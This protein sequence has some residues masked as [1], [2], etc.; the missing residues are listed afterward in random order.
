M[1]AEAQKFLS[2]SGETLSEALNA[3]T[4]DINTLVNKTIEDTM[5]NAKQYEAARWVENGTSCF[6]SAGWS[7]RLT[8][9]LHVISRYLQ[10]VNR[11]NKIR[12]HFCYKKVGGLSKGR[13]RK[14]FWEMLGNH[15]LKKTREV[16][17]VVNKG[18]LSNST[19]HP[20]LHESSMREG[21]LGNVESSNGSRNHL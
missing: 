5:I 3:F 4:S 9:H 21:I 15:K 1:N 16:V 20:I 12:L 14:A 2:K 19:I 18:I 6:L 7:A 17:Q 10:C 11:K 8:W 13:H